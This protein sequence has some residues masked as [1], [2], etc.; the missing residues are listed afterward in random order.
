MRRLTIFSFTGGKIRGMIKKP[1]P[2]LYC[3]HLCRL[4]INLAFVEKIPPLGRA[5]SISPLYTVI[6]CQP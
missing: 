6:G 2:L 1:V 5:T 4:A 3:F